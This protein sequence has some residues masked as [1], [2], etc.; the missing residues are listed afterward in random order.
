MKHAC[1]GQAHDDVIHASLIHT[2]V[3][4]GVSNR[5]PPDL[6]NQTLRVS[7]LLAGSFRQLVASILE[8]MPHISLE[9]SAPIDPVEGLRGR[10]S[11]DCRPE[12]FQFLIRGLLDVL[13]VVEVL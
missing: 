6:R 8:R 2:S 10:V 11:H 9:E 13:R 3:A 5:R 12:F 7:Q 1:F 4:V